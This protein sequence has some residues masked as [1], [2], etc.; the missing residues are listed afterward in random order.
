MAKDHRGLLGPERPEANAGLGRSFGGL[1]ILVKN[2]RKPG[3]KLIVVL[4]GHEG[5]NIT[6]LVRREDAEIVDAVHV[7]GMDVRIPHHVHVF[8]TRSKQLEPEFRRRIDQKRALVQL[9]QRP[10]ARPPV[11]GVP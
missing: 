9:E 3:S 10:V 4:L 6:P 11:P 8:D 7:V 5:R 2:I 1:K